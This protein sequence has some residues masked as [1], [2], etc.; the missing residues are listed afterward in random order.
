MASLLYFSF[1]RTRQQPP[2]FAEV[3][4]LFDH[5]QTAGK[6]PV[7][8]SQQTLA[9]LQQLK[10]EYEQNDIHERDSIGHFVHRQA[11]KLGLISSKRLDLAHDQ[12]YCVEMKN[13]C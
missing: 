1:S 7:H 6:K 13:L 9:T 12:M 3:D 10:D 11:V 5:L 4:Q 8:M 2:Y